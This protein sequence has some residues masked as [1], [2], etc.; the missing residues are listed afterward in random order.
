MIGGVDVTGSGSCSVAL[1]ATGGAE[2]L[3][4]ATAV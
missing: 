4:S 2:S 1:V 3:G